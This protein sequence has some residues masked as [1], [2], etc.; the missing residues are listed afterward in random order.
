MQ[1]IREMKPVSKE[2]NT[3]NRN[4]KMAQVFKAANKN[5][6]KEILKCDHKELIDQNSLKNKKYKS[7]NQMEILKLKSMFSEMKP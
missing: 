1:K 5:M 4:T 2:K 6:P 3:L 7:I